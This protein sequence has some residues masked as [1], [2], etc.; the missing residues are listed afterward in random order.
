VSASSWRFVQRSFLAAAAT[1]SGWHLAA[2]PASAAP[3]KPPA[4]AASSTPQRLSEA[5]EHFLAGR[6]AR[7]RALFDQVLAHDPGA[8]GRATIAFN[9]A[10]SSYALEEYADALT[11]FEAI[12]RTFPEIAELARV[13]AGFAALRLGDLKAAQAF[14]EAEPRQADVEQRRQQLL[15]ELSREREA[16]QRRELTELIDSG[17]DA[18]SQQRWAAARASFQ[19]AIALS[20][21]QARSDL[22][23]AHYGLALVASAAGDWPRAE[24]H[25]EQSLVQRP[26]DARTLLALGRA[27]EEASDASRAEAA[28]ES[29]LK[30][31]LQP[32]QVED[33][34][35]SLRR[36]YPLPLTGATAFAAFAAGVD[37]NATQSGSAD[38]VAA[39]AGASRTS[40]TL[41]GMLELGWMFRTTRRAALG[42]NYSGDLLAL[43]ASGVSELSLQRHEL[44]GRVQWAPNP[45]VRLR[46]DAG[47]AHLLTG[48]D[49]MLAFTSEGVLALAG[50]LAT[51]QRSRARVQLSE[52]L[53][54]A[55]ELSYLGGHHMQLLASEL[56]SLGAWELSL[57]G[58]LR[59]NAAG[60]QELELQPNQ[61]RG[62]GPSCARRG[63]RNPQSYWSPGAGAGAAW[64]ATA[65]L[66]CSALGR[67]EYRGYLDPSGIPGLQAS[68]K[69]RQDWRWR[70]Q[71]GAELNLDARHQL[72]LTLQ[73]TLLVS[74][75]NVAYDARDAAHQ[76]DYGDRNFVQPTTELG[77][78]ASFP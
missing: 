24:Q 61:Y 5:A 51:G 25:F 78:S 65:A 55:S 28:Y 43:L 66:R 52:R 45:E 50:D 41:S 6:Y 73:Q 58:L 29:A 63:Y 14:A 56:W 36:L 16:R 75:S 74:R 8:P 72:N 40:A 7:A 39:S 33:T 13:N 4:S 62:C 26:G 37:G 11:R 47:A 77:I 34:E 23:D 12:V 9:A 44:V 64:Q 71:L 46:V 22:A 35:R 70:G 48:L 57:L 20:P 21:A 10:V 27:A 68:Q 54:R 49:P 18:V 42:L 2:A 3:A 32:A 69:A 31:P 67:I 30:L 53:V 59:Y 60:T 1:V 76:Y 17:F 15:Q 38:V 19:Q